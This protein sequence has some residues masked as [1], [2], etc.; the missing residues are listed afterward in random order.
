MIDWNRSANAYAATTRV[1][2]AAHLPAAT[3]AVAPKRVVRHRAHAAALLSVPRSR[4][5]ITIR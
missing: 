1:A 3:W 2:G 4:S 5:R